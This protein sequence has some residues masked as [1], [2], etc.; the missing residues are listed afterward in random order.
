MSSLGASGG[1]LLELGKFAA[2]LTVPA[3]VTFA[4]ATDSKTTLYKLMGFRSYVVYPPEGPRPPSLEELRE[5]A[6]EIRQKSNSQ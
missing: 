5:M 1:W 6:P 3:A 4:I 2:Y